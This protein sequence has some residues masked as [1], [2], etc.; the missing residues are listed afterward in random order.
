MTEAIR[1][2][3]TDP[4]FVDEIKEAGGENILMC[5]QCGTCT[6]SCPVREIDERYDPL[7][8]MRMAVLGMKKEVLSSDIIWLCSRCYA[9][10]EHCPQGVKITEVLHA[11]TNIAERES[12]EGNI[13]IKSLKPRLDGVFNDLIRKYGRLFEI[14]FFVHLALLGK[15]AT[16][17]LSSVP[18]GFAMF[19]KGKLRLVPHRIKGMKQIERIFKIVEANKK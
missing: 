17:L 19:R 2:T 11:I 1:L 14:K 13:K 9:C 7:K 16:G 6:S 3:D 5:Y 12:K 4:R 10:H 8:I 18:D 15:G